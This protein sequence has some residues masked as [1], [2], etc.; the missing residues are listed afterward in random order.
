MSNGTI[1]HGPHVSPL[2][3]IATPSD[4]QDL[5]NRRPRVRPGVESGQGLRRRGGARY[6]GEIIIFSLSPRHC[7]GWPKIV[8]FVCLSRNYVALLEVVHGK[9]PAR[10]DEG[11]DTLPPF[12]T[13]YAVGVRLVMLWE[14][15][16]DVSCIMGD[17]KSTGT[18]HELSIHHG[19]SA[20]HTR[21]PALAPIRLAFGFIYQNLQYAYCSFDFIPLRFISNENIPRIF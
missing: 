10:C 11:G 5:P 15:L 13:H 3:A 19:T 14:F 6:Q 7:A 12:Q 18:E 2:L 4:D 21:T 9:I 16:L 1:R 17:P 8:P 20:A